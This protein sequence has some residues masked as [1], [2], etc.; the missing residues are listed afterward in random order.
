MTR[1][2]GDQDV[3]VRRDPSPMA[4]VKHK[5]TAALVAT[6]ATVGLTTA[7]AGSASAA[8]ADISPVPCGPSDYLQVWWHQG[9]DNPGT[10]ENCYAN[11]GT[12]TFT[13][14]YGCWL[15]AFSTGNNVVQYE[16]DGNWQP[17]TPVGKNTY[18]DFP[19]HPG[20]VELDALKIF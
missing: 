12:M 16:S 8:P 18:F 5:I 3:S 4:N 15:D 11:A 1:P 10:W 17:S 6:V 14:W 13:C 20:G 2:R 19:N 9:G 7:T